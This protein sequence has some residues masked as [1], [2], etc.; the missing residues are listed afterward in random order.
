[1]PV[2]NKQTG[3]WEDTPKEAEKKTS[4]EALKGKDITKLT[5]KEKD[6]LLLQMARD[7]GYL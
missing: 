5:A 6:D 3:K 2:L 1:M 7:L 4:K